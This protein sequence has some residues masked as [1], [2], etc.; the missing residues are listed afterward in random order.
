MQYLRE[1][2]EAL[3]GSVPCRNDDAPPLEVPSLAD[4]QKTL[5]NKAGQQRTG[6][7]NLYHDGICSPAQR[8]S[9]R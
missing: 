5:Q 9:P 6:Q 8:S 4:Y 1:R 7:G 3:G 2:R